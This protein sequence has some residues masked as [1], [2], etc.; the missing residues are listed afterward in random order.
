MGENFSLSLKVYDGKNCFGFAFLFLLQ[1]MIQFLGKYGY[2]DDAGKVRE[3]EY[4]ASRRGF[5]PAGE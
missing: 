3:I 5:E 4:G 2:V 1:I